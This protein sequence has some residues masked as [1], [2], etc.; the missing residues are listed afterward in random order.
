MTLFILFDP[1][2][3]LNPVAGVSPDVLA[4]CD[5]FL[6]VPQARPKAS[7]ETSAGAW[8]IS[9]R[10]PRRGHLHV[11]VAGQHQE[12]KESHLRLGRAKKLPAAVYVCIL[13]IFI[14][15][16]IYNCI[17]N[18][19]LF[20]AQSVMGQIW[21]VV[22]EGGILVRDGSRDDSKVLEEKLSRDAFVEEIEVA[23]ECLG[24]VRNAL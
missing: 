11:P 12:V 23:N 1:F 16:Y 9:E 17:Y 15:N 3:A 4:C 7:R 20:S 18:V 22:E 5:E 19:L 10:R 24:E 8:G 21:Q 6:C 14:Y 13:Y 2:F